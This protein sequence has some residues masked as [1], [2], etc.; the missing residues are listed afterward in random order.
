RRADP[1]VRF[2]ALPGDAAG[3]RPLAARGRRG[4]VRRVDAALAPRG[5]DLDHLVEALEVGLEREAALLAVFLGDGADQVAHPD[6]PVVVGGL[7]GGGQRAVADRAAG[8][9]ELPGQEVEVDVL[10][11]RRLVREYA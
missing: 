3:A 6:R 7:E 11:D 2:R 9:L 4:A 5:A 10:G 1:H 8:E